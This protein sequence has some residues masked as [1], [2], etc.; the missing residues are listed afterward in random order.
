MDAN[1]RKLLEDDGWQVDC[2]SPFELSDKDGSRAS[3]R[4]ADYVLSYLQD[5][6]SSE[7]RWCTDCSH[8]EALPGKNVCEKCYLG[9]QAHE[10]EQEV[11]K[12]S[13]CG[14]PATNTTGTYC[15]EHEHEH[16][17]F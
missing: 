3:G 14:A 11:R 7:L 2:E 4:A 16:L 12:C 5:G 9:M 8:A 6:D 17:V 13:E 15:Q 1:D 10:R